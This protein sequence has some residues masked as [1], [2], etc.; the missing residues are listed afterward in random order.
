[1]GPAAGAGS[2]GAR[3]SA[4]WGN[5]KEVLGCFRNAVIEGVPAGIIEE[6]TGTEGGTIRTDYRFFGSGPIFATMTEASLPRVRS[7]SSLGAMILGFDGASW[8][9][10]PLSLNPQGEFLIAD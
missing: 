10:H 7:T 5:P 3:S 6:T 8:S 9:Y 2:T 4:V 1:M